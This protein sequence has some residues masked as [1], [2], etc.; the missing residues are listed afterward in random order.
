MR[1]PPISSSMIDLIFCNVTHV[2]T[3]RVIDMYI[4][5]HQSI[6]LI[7]KMNTSLDQNKMKRKFTG[8]TYMTYTPMAMQNLVDDTM[9][10]VNGLMSLRDLTDCWN[11]LYQSLISIADKKIPEKQYTVNNELPAW[12]TPELL[13]L[14][15]ANITGE[16][17]DWFIARNLRNRTNI[18]MR[19]VKAEYI[20][21]QLSEN[22]D[23]PDKEFRKQINSEILP[24]INKTTFNFVDHINNQGD[25]PTLINNYFSE[26][27]Y[28]CIFCLC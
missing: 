22:K 24:E 3:S 1:V 8:W 28:I 13:N 2:H 17:G 26:I 6:Y 19:A 23:N 25:I 5:D 16:D 15:K 20:K 10:D 7:K 14:K 12:L 11:C 27:V 9:H 4:I 21:D 18:A